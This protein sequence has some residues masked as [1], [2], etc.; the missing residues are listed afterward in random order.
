MLKSRCRWIT[1]YSIHGLPWW[2]SPWKSACQCR[3]H[4]FDHWS[5]KIPH[6]KWKPLSHVQLFATP[7]TIVHGILQARILEWVAYP[8]SGG[9]SQPRD[10]TE[11]SCIAGRFFTSWATREAK[12]P[13]ASGQ[14][15]QCSKFSKPGFNSTWTENLQMFK[16]DLEKAEEPE[17]K[18]PTSVGSLKKQQ[19]CRKT[20]TLLYGLGQSLWLCGSQ[21]TLENSSRDGNTRLPYLPLEKP[22]CRSGSN[23]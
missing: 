13:Y 12:I 8:F 1:Q 9:S 21:Q 23:S 2:S 7:W 14:L 16:L 5:G 6:E 15:K 22:V 3:G 11:V 10:Q 19:S 18:L 20:S 4:R 17:I